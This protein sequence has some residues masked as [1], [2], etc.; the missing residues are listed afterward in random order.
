MFV[1]WLITL[2]KFLFIPLAGYAQ[3]IGILSVATFKFKRLNT[4]LTGTTHVY[5]MDAIFARKFFKRQPV[6]ITTRIIGAPSQVGLAHQL[7]NGF[8]LRDGRRQH[9]GFQ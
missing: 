8:H 9:R 1:D 2:D 7:F 5:A 3:P 4:R 6:C